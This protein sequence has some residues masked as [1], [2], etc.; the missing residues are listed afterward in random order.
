MR[1]G[2]LA[3]IAITVIIISILGVSFTV[4]AFDHPP[5][6]AKTSSVNAC[7]LL[8]PSQIDDLAWNG[9]GREVPGLNQSMP[10]WNYQSIHEQIQQGWESLCQNPA[11]ITAIQ[12]HGT[13]SFSSGGGFVNPANPDLSQ[14]G[15]VVAW[16]QDAS[17][18]CI[19]Y[20]ETWGIFIINGTVTA[21]LTSTGGCIS[22]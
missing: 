13:R 17:M 6:S 16:T 12:V 20:I 9:V 4:L 22:A 3:G 14:M 21:P 18:N 5:S 2:L 15:V 11:F 7:D 1:Q 19:Q 10:P 8:T